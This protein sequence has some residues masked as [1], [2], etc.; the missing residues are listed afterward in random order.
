M[1]PEVN[2]KTAV[3]ALAW[4]LFAFALRPVEDFDV[5]WQLQTGKYL[6]QTKA[7]LYTDTFSLAVDAFRLEH[8][9][10]HDIILFALY[11]LGGFPLVSL[12]KTA[13]VT[14]YA[15]LLYRWNRFKGVE[16]AFTLPTLALCLIAS[17][18]SWA[19]RPQLWTFLFSLLYLHLLHRGRLEGLRAWGWLVPIMLFWSNLHAACIFGFVLIG[20]FISAELVRAI[21]G[22]ASWQSVRLLSFVG[23]LTFAISFINPYGWRIPVGALLAHI[24]QYKVHL[25]TA[26]TSMAGNMEWL[27][28]TFAQVP[29]FYVV[30][31]L[32]GG[33]ILWRLR[34]IDP[35]EAIFFLAFV[36][37]G[38]GQIRHTTLVSLLAGYYLPLALKE[39][40][41]T[42]SAKRVPLPWA[43]ISV[44]TTFLLLLVLLGWRSTH[45][46]WGWGL[47]KSAFPV[48][49]TDFILRERLPSGLYNSYDWG[50]Y[51]MWRLFPDYLVFVDGRQD[52]PEHFESSNIIDNAA[53][54]WDKE[55][56]RYGIDTI[57]TRTCYYDT[58]E[59][60]P[61]V[62]ALV[63]HPGWTLVF[64]D[65]QSVVFLRRAEHFDSLL[66]RFALPSRQAYETVLVEAGQLYRESKSRKMALLSSGRAS[67]HLGRFEESLAFYRGYL[68]EEPDD[69]ESLNRVEFLTGRLGIK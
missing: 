10:L 3:L 32:W 61:L 1:F 5:F 40:V 6:W 21:Q 28:P 22:R 20:L 63:R 47:K 30:F 65:D 23:V 34:R 60:L 26:S 17:E 9:W 12:L 2:R 41:E 29:Y 39:T 36:Y 49:A 66:N 31:V 57:I 68:E 64:Q 38:F 7:F 55:L 13:F 46:Q 45:Q 53:P 11:S 14:I 19:E 48:A 44:C 27:P 25:G 15:L 67:L 54:G 37:M 16:P 33:A 52:S 35:A 69:P 58:G 59:P 56:Q 18:P 4:V 42:I 43:R 24:N 50:G 62:D 8:C 51:L